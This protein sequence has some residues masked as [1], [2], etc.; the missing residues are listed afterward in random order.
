MTGGISESGFYAWETLIQGDLTVT[1]SVA[2]AGGLTINDIQ[3]SS[4]VDAFVFGSGSEN[5]VIHQMTGNLSLSASTGITVNMPDNTVG[6]VG[7]ASFAETASYFAGTVLSASFA[8]SS[9]SASFAS[10]STSAS[11]ASS[12]TSASFAS[13]SISASH[14][15]NSISAS[16]AST[17]ISASHVDTTISASYA[18]SSTSA[19]FASSSTSA[20]FATNA[21]TASHALGIIADGDITGNLI[22]D[23][24]GDLTG[25]VSGNLNGTA[26]FLESF[27]SISDTPFTYANSGS[28]VLQV[29][30]DATE[31]HFVKT[32]ESASFA[33]ESISSS[34][35]L[36][37]SYISTSN[38]AG[39]I[40]DFI[41]LEDTAT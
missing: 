4:S 8:S 16:F 15:D 2:I 40:T 5:T 17:S 14:A 11:F 21:L 22:G 35:A 3:V 36:T 29:A 39:L 24:T 31:I 32:I 7:T 28:F 6:F 30:P 23:V 1:G 26:S 19:S 37:A 34:F 33:S 12:S 10:S 38:I 18:S 41:G 27:L 13:S 20:S 25:S 9:T